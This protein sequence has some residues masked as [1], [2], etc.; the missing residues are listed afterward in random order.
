MSNWHSETSASA[1]G[2]TSSMAEPSAVSSL[3]RTINARY[4]VSLIWTNTKGFV[5][6]SPHAVLLLVKADSRGTIV[7]R[8]NAPLTWFTAMGIELKRDR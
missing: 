5:V 6:G 1:W 3:L 8:A 7:E 4:R 2:R